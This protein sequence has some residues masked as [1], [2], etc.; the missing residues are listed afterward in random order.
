MAAQRYPPRPRVRQREANELRSRLALMH[1]GAEPAIAEAV[2][3]RNASAAA[4][5]APDHPAG[6]KPGADV[7][8]PAIRASSEF[9]RRPAWERRRNHR[10]GPRAGGAPGRG[11]QPD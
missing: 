7:K 4:A 2:A 8:Q 10:L 9:R 1:A 11:G 6:A 3:H 5:A